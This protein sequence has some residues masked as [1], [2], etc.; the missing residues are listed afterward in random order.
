MSNFDTSHKSIVVTMLL[1]GLMQIVCRYTNISRLNCM[2]VTLIL[3]IL[4]PSVT[5]CGKINY[6]NSSNN[7]PF[8]SFGSKEE[9]HAFC[10]TIEKAGEFCSKNKSKMC[11]DY[12]KSLKQTKHN[13]NKLLIQANKNS[14]DGDATRENK[15]DV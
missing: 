13:L 10:D 8:M 3:F 14:F 2:A 9:K 12:T 5:N 6:T 4:L 1:I 15:P 11:K 7:E